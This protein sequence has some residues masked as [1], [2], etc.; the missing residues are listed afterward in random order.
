MYVHISVPIYV[1]Y[2]VH[3]W[4]PIRA[5]VYTQYGCVPD[6]PRIC[7]P[8]RTRATERRGL[9]STVCRSYSRA[10]GIRCLCVRVVAITSVPFTAAGAIREPAPG[11]GASVFNIPAT[12]LLGTRCASMPAFQGVSHIVS[13]LSRQ[14]QPAHQ[15]HRARMYARACVSLSVTS[16]KWGGD[17]AYMVSTSDK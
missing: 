14:T 8:A 4:V 6:A 7:T 1:P 12:V 13:V 10:G 16:D 2:M 5:S 15:T 9:R 3:I 11:G 17:R